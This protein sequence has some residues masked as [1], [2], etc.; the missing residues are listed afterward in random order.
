MTYS[1]DELVLGC[2]LHDMGKFLQRAHDRLS[3]VVGEPLDLESTLCPS[4]KGIYTHKH[5]LYTN[6]FFDMMRRENLTFPGMVNA[7]TVEYIASFHHKPD[8]SPIPSASWLCALGDRYSAG[9]DRR[10]DEETSERSSSRTAFRTTPLQCIF[11]EIILDQKALG[12]PGRHAYRLSSL[13]PENPNTLIPLKWPSGGADPQ[14]PA[15]YSALWKQY[16]EDFRRLGKH[17]PRLSVRLF[18]ESLL[19]LLERFTWAIPSSTVDAPDVSLYDHVRTTTAIAAALYRYHEASGDLDDINAIKAGSTPKFR[20]VAGDLS[21]IQSTLFTLQTQ[22]V[23]GVNK[24]LRAR[25]FLMGAITE[26][27]ALLTL[28]AFGLPLSSIVQLAGGRFLVLAPALENIEETL[29]EMRE[30]FDLWLLEKYTGSLAVNLVASPPFP[31]TSFN[32]HPLRDVMR[33]LNWAIEDGK[34]RPLSKCRQGVVHR[35]YPH[36]TA[37]MA[38][39]VRPGEKP[40]EASYRCPT[41]ETEHQLGRMLVDANLMVWGKDLPSKWRPLEVLGLEMAV[42]EEHPLESMESALSIRRTRPEEMPI[43]WAFRSLANHVPIFK[44][45][46]EWQDPRYDW[47]RDADM[48]TGAGCL[49]SFSHIASEALE[50]SGERAFRGRPFLGLLKADVDYLGFIFGF[51]LKRAEEGSDRFTLSRLAQLSRMFDLYFTGYVKGLL[52]REFNSTYTVYAGG[53]DLLLIGPWRQ[54][55]SLTSRINE[56]FRAYTGNNPNITISAGVTLL[57][58]H[59]PVNRAVREAEEYL[60][61]SKE[62]GRNRVCALIPKAV[63]WERF[64]ERMADAEWIHQ[65]MQGDSPVSTGFV[66]RILELAGEAESVASKA[67]VRKAGWRAR[68]AYH[69]ARNIKARTSVE[70]QQKIIEWLEHLGLDDQFRLTGDQPNIV[71]WRLPLS[72][73][74]YRNRT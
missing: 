69:L 72:I 8:S 24:I 25:S 48:E 15:Q 33:Q 41:C 10:E 65:R 50:T 29:D 13:D 2:L 21:G 30:R 66:Y 31:G 61:E 39:G 27:A 47:I 4:R 58:P 34:Q 7:Q 42:L 62:Q 74:L 11:D 19:G 1:L 68:L 52:H 28:E 54:T 26:S 37:C 55:L 18:E 9:M 16:W 53:D 23:R 64:N 35:E 60:E 14:L 63:S 6:A 5:V 59:Y 38:C 43:P 71:D 44:D 3:D 56:T 70:R 36:D 17:G 49:K 73:A 51:G 45:D 40:S 32:S 22:G 57:K 20:F 67:D 12:K 46:Y